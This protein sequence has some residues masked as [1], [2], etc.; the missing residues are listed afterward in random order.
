MFPSLL[1]TYHTLGKA[2]PVHYLK[3]LTTLPKQLSDQIALCTK[4]VTFSNEGT[5]VKLSLIH[6]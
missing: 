6:I 2:R 3:T 5:N 4:N 1:L